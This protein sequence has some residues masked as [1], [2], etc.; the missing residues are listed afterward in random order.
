MISLSSCEINFYGSN[1]DLL[2]GTTWIDSWEGDHGR[3]YEQRFVFYPGGRGEEYYFD[4]IE[5]IN[6]FYWHWEDN[7]RT[8]VMAYGPSNVSYFDDVYIGRGTLSGYLNEEYVEFEA[9]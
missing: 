1:T 8:I 4:G 3:Y 6:P 9:W 2:C 5:H 7:E